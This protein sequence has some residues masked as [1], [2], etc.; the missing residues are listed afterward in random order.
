MKK[1]IKASVMSS[2]VGILFSFSNCGCLFRRAFSVSN[3]FDTF[4][5]LFNIVAGL[6]DCNPTQVFSCEIREFSRTTF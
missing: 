4:E 5:S 6:K 1:Q 3:F 2:V